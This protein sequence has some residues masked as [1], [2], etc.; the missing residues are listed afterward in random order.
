[1]MWGAV[2]CIVFALLLSM[3][4]QFSH[5]W[6]TFDDQDGLST[7]LTTI[8]NDCSFSEDV[9]ECKRTTYERYSEDWMETSYPKDGEGVGDVITGEYEDYCNNVFTMQT[10]NGW[11]QESAEDARDTCLEAP[12][13]GGMASLILWL[14]TIGALLGTV[15]LSSG[16]IGRSLSAEA[17]KHGK[18]AAMAA[19]AL[20]L[21]AVLAWSQLMPESVAETSLGM[22]VWLTVLGGVLGL[23]AGVLAFLDQK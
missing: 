8:R 5:A 10:E 6:V 23:V 22:G 17:E 19:G 21:L 14:G 15:M 4:G 12:G 13:A 3:A 1:M 18:W 7:G 11:S 9:E 20:A 16:A 2:A